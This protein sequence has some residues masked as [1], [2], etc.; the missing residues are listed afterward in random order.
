MCSPLFLQ[1][2]IQV[3]LSWQKIMFWFVLSHQHDKIWCK[4]SDGLLLLTALYCWNTSMHRPAEINRIHW[5]CNSLFGSFQDKGLI[6]SK[7]TNM[8]IF[9]PVKQSNLSEFIYWIIPKDFNSGLQWAV[10]WQHWLGVSIHG[11]VPSPSLCAVWIMAV[12]GFVGIFGVQSSVRQFV[13][14]LHLTRQL[15]NCVI[16]LKHNHCDGA[17]A[18]NQLW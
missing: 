18:N 5:T 13:H 3:R 11:L 16:F 2:N 8:S 4:C 6:S 15:L 12:S 7:K 1:K 9:L 10:N 14:S 17:L